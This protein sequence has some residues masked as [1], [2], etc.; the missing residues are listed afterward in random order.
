MQSI[1]N[2]YKNADRFVGFAD[3]Y[4][5]A[6][7]AV[8]GYPVRIIRNY[9]EK[10][11]DTVVDLGCGTG[12]S[13]L[14]WKENC[15]HIIGIEPSADMLKKAKEKECDGFSFQ[16]G[17]GNETGLASEC[18]DVVICSQSFHWMEP[19][20]TL[21]EIDRILR[22]G[23]I[24]ATIDYDWPPIIKWEAE[25]AYTKLYEKVQ[26]YEK[27]LPDVK[28]TYIRY[29]KEK[30]LANMK[31][32]GYFRYCREIVFSNTENCTAQRLVNMLL[33]QGG[34]HIILRLHPELIHEE[35]EHFQKAIDRLYLEKTFDIDFS[36]RMRIGV[37]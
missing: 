13:S 17:F 15:R 25:K 3:T 12:L 20:S 6:R 9:L 27:E 32:S 11:P 5:Q 14:I 23:G 28:N 10:V 22:N 34:V 8:P 26:K 1:S 29:S 30:H 4:D 2:H 19:Q 21:R 31:A 33:S 16:T 18:A 24:F 7:P 37:K 35:M 36:Y